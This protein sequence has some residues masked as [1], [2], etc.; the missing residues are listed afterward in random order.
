MESAGVGGGQV[1]SV[2]GRFVLRGFGEEL[3]VDG[4]ALVAPLYRDRGIVRVIGSERLGNPAHSHHVLE[5]FEKRFQVERKAEGNERSVL[6]TAPQLHRGR[7]DLDRPEL[8]LWLLQIAIA[9]GIEDARLIPALSCQ[10]SPFERAR[11]I[12]ANHVQRESH[13]KPR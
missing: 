11:R 13:V 2:P 1:H 6:R 4:L 12:T 10:K 5:G 3:K 8:P 9:E 7:V